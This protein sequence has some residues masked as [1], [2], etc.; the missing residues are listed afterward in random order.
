MVSSDN[1][2]MIL[3]NNA[4]YSLYV[5]NTNTLI[6]DFMDLL[7]IE[8]TTKPSKCGHRGAGCRRRTSTPVLAPY[9][10]NNGEAEG[11]VGSYGN[12]KGFQ[13]FW[14]FAIS[15]TSGVPR[16][17]NAMRSSEAILVVAF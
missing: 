2:L 13:K 6:I 12:L 15:I 11:R 9:S 4:K 7:S 14:K 5:C 17:P 8:M 3:T 10:N 1:V 16:R